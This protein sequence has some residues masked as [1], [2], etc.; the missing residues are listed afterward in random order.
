MSTSVLGLFTAQL[1]SSVALTNVNWATGAKFMQVELDLGS[2]FVD[3]GTQQ[4]LSVPYALDS[5]N[6]E[7]AVRAGNGFESV[8]ASGDTLFLT[9][10]NFIQI[11]GIS[12]ANGGTSF[13]TTLHTCGEANIH[14]S[15]LIYGSMT[16]Q[17]GNVYKTV[18]I[19]T[20]EWMAENLN[21]SIYRNGDPIPTGLDDAT[22]NNT[23]SGAWTYHNND[24][25]NECPY[26]KLYNWYT[27]VD[28]RELCP[29]GWHVPNDGEWT[30]LSD[31]L[32]GENICGGPMKSTG[33]MENS[34]GL[35]SS[36][37]TGA[38][39]FTGF[40]AIPSG[41]RGINGSYIH[42][43]TIGFAWSTTS[44]SQSNAWNRAWKYNDATLNKFANLKLHG[45]SVRCVRD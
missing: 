16:D 44:T 40:S 41:A 30:L 26:G 27:C 6:S 4:L 32:G 5:R 7:N 18:V 8:S 31:Y 13:G 28:P 14:Q 17:E 9:N 29:T 37:N 24:V 11:P 45:F 20:Q 12:Q 33:I 21:T 43:L 22:W 10:G 19:G 23:T 34:T 1:G 38:T 42:F 25:S 15:N 3:I 36:P 39:N 2:G 35:W